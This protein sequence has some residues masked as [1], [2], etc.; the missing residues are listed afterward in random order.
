MPPS[1][2]S[3]SGSTRTTVALQWST[4]YATSSA[5][6][7][8]LIG[9]TMRPYA[10]T[11]KNDVSK[12]AELWLTIATRSPCPTPSASRAAA[13]ARARAAIS[14]YVNEPHDAAG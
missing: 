1:T 4:M 11:P 9:T 2:G 6:S 14:R 3:S 8:K 10:L 12:R 13:W 5:L 7:R